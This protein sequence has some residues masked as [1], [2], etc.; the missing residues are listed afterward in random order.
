MAISRFPKAPKP[1]SDFFSKSLKKVFTLEELDSIF[2]EHIGK[3][4]L[5][6]STTE[7]FAKQLVQSNILK[8][9]EFQFG[10]RISPQ[11]RFWSPIADIYDVVLSLAPKIHFSHTSALFLH[12]I[13]KTTP[14]SIYITSEQSKKESKTNTSE[15]EQNAI[16]IAFSKPQRQTNAKCIFKGKNIFL[17]HGMFTNKLGIIEL[18]G[19]P[20]TSLERTLLDITVRPSYAGGVSEVLKAFINAK[21]KVDIDIL[22]NLL[23][24]IN[25]TYPYYQSIGFYLEKAGYNAQHISK[26]KKREKYVDFYIDYAM[27]DPIHSIDW[28]LFYPKKLEN[29]SRYNP[30]D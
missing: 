26:L 12:G 15:L 29:K 6:V 13:V 30:Q 10:E 20:V 27:V 25:Y 11:I 18:S 16:D 19:K 8:G 17:L 14:M 3:W 7:N 22:I 1:V 21:N 9:N 24:N 23:D 28:R 5:P 2:Q 4:S